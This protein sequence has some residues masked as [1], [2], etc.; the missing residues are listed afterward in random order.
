MKTGRKRYGST[1]A[2]RKVIG[3]VRLAS[4]R[5][6]GGTVPT[7][8]SIADKLNA[9]GHRTK[10]GKLFIPQTISSIQARIKSG[11]FRQ[12]PKRVKKTQLTS[13]DFRSEEQIKY[14]IKQLWHL[15]KYGCELSRIYRIL[16]G[17][18]LRASE[19]CDL[20][21]GDIDPAKRMVNVR[22]GKGAKQRTVIISKDTADMLCHLTIHRPRRQPV[23]TNRS[24]G[25]LSY[26]ALYR[27]GRKIA[28]IIGDPAFHLHS[29]RHTFATRLYNYKKDLKFVGEQLGHSSLQTTG[30]YAKTLNAEKLQQMDA[31][32]ALDNSAG[33]RAIEQDTTSKLTPEQRK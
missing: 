22:R 29:L 17:T 7:L 8:Q 24:G 33:G 18:G 32:D 6:R 10:T 1:D 16:V 9:A 20:R 15:E 25:R 31:M 23:F 26:N 30:I 14:D 12:R 4:R 21:C 3:V 2:E 11:E 28:K 19:F 5:V 27:R 13:G